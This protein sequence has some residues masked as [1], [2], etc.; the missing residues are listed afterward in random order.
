MSHVPYT[1]NSVNSQPTPVQTV[2]TQQRRVNSVNTTNPPVYSVPHQQPTHPVQNTA[3]TQDQVAH[4]NNP[5]PPTLVYI[6]AAAQTKQI[7][8]NYP[9]GLPLLFR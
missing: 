6:T 1:T 5:Q 2:H 9:Q 8:T 3:P 7:Q 4:K